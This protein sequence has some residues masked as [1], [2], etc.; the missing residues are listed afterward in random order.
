MWVI[1]AFPSSQR[2]LRRL[3][4]RSSLCF[5]GKSVAV[6]FAIPKTRPSLLISVAIW[7]R[8][9]RIVILTGFFW[10]VNLAGAIYG[11][12]F[13][14]FSRSVVEILIFLIHSY[15]KG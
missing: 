11:E 10:L 12:H 14:S 6:S 9:M 3:L 2:G 4:P 13:L 1:N 8:D 7:G 15:H 5:E